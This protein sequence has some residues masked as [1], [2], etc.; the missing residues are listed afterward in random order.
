[1]VKDYK[2]FELGVN[3]MGAGET[4]KQA[5]MYDLLQLKNTGLSLDLS[6]TTCLNVYHDRNK[7]HFLN[8]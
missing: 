6:F 7:E 2:S 5:I 8:L 4:V 3:P 1:M